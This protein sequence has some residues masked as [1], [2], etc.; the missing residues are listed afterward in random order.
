MS[1]T[2]QPGQ[3]YLMVN[4]LYTF[5]ATGA[6]TGGACMI[7]DA[8][9][10]PGGGPPPHIHTRET[11]TFVVLQGHITC[12]QEGQTRTLGPGESISLPPHKAHT[13]RN[14]T[15]APA[16]MLV[17]CAPAA[18]ERMFATAGTPVPPGTAPGPA[19]PPTPQELET[20]ARACDEAGIRFVDKA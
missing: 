17:I 6:Q 19:R 7:I 9:V 2:P 14:L 18:I 11:E 3:T 20:I 16:R 10:P 4:D 12:T 13:F 5:L 8:L 15:D 1:T